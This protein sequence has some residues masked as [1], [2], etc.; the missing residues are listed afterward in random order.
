[1]RLATAC[2]RFFWERCGERGTLEMMAKAGFDAIDYTFCNWMEEGVSPWTKNDAVDHAKELRR[3]ADGCGICFHQ[4]HAP[5]RFDP[6]HISDWHR[7]MI[8]MI[9][10]SMELSALLGAPH[11][12]VHPLHHVPYAQNREYLWNLNQDYYRELLPYARQFGINIAL[13]NLVERTPP[14]ER[15]LVKTLCSEPREY[16]AFY[17]ALNAEEQMVCCVDTGHA[18]LGGESAAEMIRV[19]GRRVKALHIHDNDLV[20]DKHWMPYQ[21]K[22]DWNAV[23][24]ALVDVDYSGDFTFEVLDTVFGKY[25]ENDFP[26]VLRF[27]HDLGRSMIGKLEAYRRER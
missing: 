26:I 15:Q 7:E 23:L 1:M 18:V 16:A 19:L 4:T 5:F 8:P 2:E 9:V 6:S 10:R 22:I 21:G 27:L 25:D 13:E 12:V 17:D 11:I 20:S 14:P 3:I 24:R